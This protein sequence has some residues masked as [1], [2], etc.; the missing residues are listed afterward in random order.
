[1][2]LFITFFLLALTVSFYCSLLESTLLSTPASFAQAYK[3]EAIAKIKEKGYHKKLKRKLISALL[4]QRFKAETEGPLS[5][6]LALNTIAHTVGAAGVGAQGAIIFGEASLG[7]IS[8]VL[9]V[10]ILILTEILPKTIGNRFWR[11]LAPKLVRIIL[12][13]MWICYPLIYLSRAISWLITR[14]QENTPSVSREEVSALVN[15]GSQEGTLEDDETRMLK[16]ILALDDLRTRDIM[17]PRTVAV[18]AS[19]EM[20]LRQFFKQKNYLKYSRIPVYEAD[21]PEAITGWV[22]LKQVFELLAEDKFDT[23]L[24]EIRRPVLW[25]FEQQRVSIL[26]DKMQETSPDGRKIVR[27]AQMAVVLD[28]YGSFAGLVTVEDIVETMLGQEIT[29]EKDIV[30]D[31]QDYARKKYAKSKHA[32]K[33]Q[34][35]AIPAIPIL[36]N[37]KEK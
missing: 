26:W 23:R 11:R 2:I 30:P 1:M 5:A 29:D 19:E 16:S 28:E 32:P 35:A 4:M 20:T 13:T 15:I 3:Q 21:N 37:Q 36:K 9:T 34:N 7:I 22:L 25:T 17:T 31:L 10:A 33:N 6:I 27:S 12:V 24:K 18:T 8:G 14:G